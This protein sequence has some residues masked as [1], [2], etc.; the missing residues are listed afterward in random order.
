MSQVHF[1]DQRIDIESILFSSY[2]LF[3]LLKVERTAETTF[4]DNHC[5]T[6][7]YIRDRC[8]VLLIPET[9]FKRETCTKLI[10]GCFDEVV[11]I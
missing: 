9:F 5:K 4:Q 2:H 1:G 11:D 6:I 10:K 8:R 7:K 3:T